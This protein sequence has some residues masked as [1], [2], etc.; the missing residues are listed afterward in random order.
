MP[1]EN[2]IRKL[3]PAGKLMIGKTKDRYTLVQ[4]AMRNVAR[5]RKYSLAQ[6]ARP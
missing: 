1:R 2:F 5:H 6:G 3:D 4:Q